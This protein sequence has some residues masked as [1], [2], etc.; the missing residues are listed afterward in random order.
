MPLVVVRQGN[1]VR[2]RLTLPTR[3]RG[4]SRNAAK[5]GAIRGRNLSKYP[6]C[7][8]YEAFCILILSENSILITGRSQSMQSL[9]GSNLR[10]SGSMQ[11]INRDLAVPHRSRSRSR[12]RNRT[13]SVGPKEII[14]RRRRSASGMRQGRGKKMNAGFIRQQVLAS[15]RGLRSNSV[16]FRSKRG[17]RNLGERLN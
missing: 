6:D 2:D 14:P 17:G 9:S 4:R 3:G 10:R 1:N 8:T 5:K 7:S 11:S 15:Q 13:P 16:N 12:T